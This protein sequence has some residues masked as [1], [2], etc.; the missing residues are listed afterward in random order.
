M[1]D[2]DPETALAIASSTDATPIVVTTAINHGLSPGDTGFIKGHA[3]NINANGAW[4]FSAVTSNTLTL[5]GSVGTGAGAGGATGNVIPYTNGG[6]GIPEDGEFADASAGGSGA[7]VVSMIAALADRIAF[8]KNASKLAIVD[9]LANGNVTV[10]DGATLAIVYGCGKGGDGN[11]GTGGVTAGGTTSASYGGGAGAGALLGMAIVPVQAG[12]VIA[13]TIGAPGSNSYS[14]FGSLC[15]F[16]GSGEGAGI[17]SGGSTANYATGGIAGSSITPNPTTSKSEAILAVNFPS[18]GGY[19]GSLLNDVFGSGAT[20]AQAPTSFGGTP[21]VGGA[22]GIAGATNSSQ[23]GGGGGGGG[24][25]GPFGNGAAGGAGGAGGIGTTGDGGAN[26]SNGAA[27]SG[28]GGGAS[29]GGGNGSASHGG[30]GTPGLGGSGRM[31]V[32]FVGGAS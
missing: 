17:P 29:G 13:C 27:N 26:G 10:P 22:G 12:E 9:V 3:T 2:F 7:T 19:G 30:P 18:S 32:A 6:I 4:V 8:V 5:S 11:S 1:I 28:A 25:A 23:N 15:S 16:A 21:F 20:G 14:T 31:V 24:G